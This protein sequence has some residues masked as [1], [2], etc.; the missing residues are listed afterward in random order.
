MRIL[1]LLL[2]L[3]G[4]TK[5]HQTNYTLSVGDKLSIE[6]SSNPTTAYRWSVSTMGVCKLD[7]V[8]YVQDPAPEGY[9]GV[10]GNET[11]HFTALHQG[12]DTLTFV[13]MTLDG[14]TAET[15]KY[16]VWVH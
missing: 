4:C 16:S 9:C 13:Y 5:H 3:V 10:G 2:I 8:T 11:H 6:H 15:R 14:D 7:S 12:I 1:F